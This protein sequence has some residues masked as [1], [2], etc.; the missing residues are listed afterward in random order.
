MKSRKLKKD[1]KLKDGTTFTKGESVAV[2]WE[3]SQAIAT[4]GART[5]KISS[6]SLARTVSGFRIPSV[7]TLER[8]SDEGYCL[9]VT[10]QKTEPDGHGS[11]GSPSWLL[12]LG[13]I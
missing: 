1:I 8:W 9:T 2:T 3:N 6:K 13:M 7:A 11:D 10:G 12:A 4:I 5:F